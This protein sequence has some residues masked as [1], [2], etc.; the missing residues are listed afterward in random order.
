MILTR[1]IVAKRGH[2]ETQTIENFMAAGSRRD[3]ILEVLVGVSL[4]TMSNYAD[5]TSPTELDQEFQAE[6]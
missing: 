3:Q 4:K 6:G 5:H 2:V 1:E